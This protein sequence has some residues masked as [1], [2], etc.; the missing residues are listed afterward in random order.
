MLKN[1]CF[2]LQYWYVFS[3]TIIHK[4]EIRV[5]TRTKTRRGGNH[6]KLNG[7]QHYQ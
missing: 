5:I 7:S 1:L 3:D 6:G 2:L 4:D